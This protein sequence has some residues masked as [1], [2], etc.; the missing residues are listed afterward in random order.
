[1]SFRRRAA[2]FWGR[3]RS[4]FWM[5]HSVWALATGV[6]VLLLA[7]ERYA[8]VPWVVVFLGLTWLSTL[9]FGSS[10]REEW[11]PTLGGEVSSYVTRSLYQETLFFLLPFYAYSTVLRSPNVAFLVLLAGLAILSCLDLVFDRWLR[12]RPVFGLVFFATV[13]FAAINLLLPILFSLPTRIATPVAALGAV[14]SSLPLALHGEGRSRAQTLRVGVASALILA[15]AMAVPALVPPVPLRLQEATFAAG[16]ERETMTPGDPIETGDAAADLP[17]R[18]VFLGQVFAPADLRTGVHV[19]WRQDGTTVR[20]SR[21]VEIV[22]HEGG[23]RVWDGL[24]EEVTPLGPG[25]YEVVLRTA[26]GRWFGRA[27]VT[28]R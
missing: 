4:L 5:L 22:A 23:F 25:R 10:A 11:T 13:A 19:E 6:V 14:A 7:R 8:F 20:T 21:E 26:A 3:H 16:I 2:A 9:F 17:G 28:L 15:I 24:T 27:V 12:T 1:M 18:L